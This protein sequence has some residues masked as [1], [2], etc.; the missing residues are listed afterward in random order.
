LRTSSVT[1]TTGGP[2]ET[3][4][5]GERLGHELFASSMVALVGEL[6]SGKTT[7]AQGIAHGLGVASSV[8]SPSFV[9]IREYEGRVP[10]YHFD[11]YRI[12]REE[13]VL[14]LGYYEYFYQK[15]GVVLVEWA[16]RIRNYLPP[17]HLRVTIGMGPRSQRKIAFDPAGTRY[18]R[19]VK[20]LF[21]DWKGG[22]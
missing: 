11:L 4:K 3:Q 5:L 1:T 17:Q 7:L 14:G 21:P 12:L 16:D 8:R 15:Q 18:E 19:I 13:E 20:R 9:L 10:L 6:G 2:E 22:E